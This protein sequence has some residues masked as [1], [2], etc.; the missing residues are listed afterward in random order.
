[1][2]KPTIE[3]Q[4][5][6]ALHMGLVPKR[7]ALFKPDCTTVRAICVRCPRSDLCVTLHDAQQEASAA[8][9]QQAS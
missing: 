6:I 3:Q 7:I 2:H 8:R 5:R 4:H 9:E 1:M